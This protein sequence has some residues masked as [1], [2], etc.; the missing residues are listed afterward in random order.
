M[1]SLSK[2]FILFTFVCNF[3]AYIIFILLSRQ[4]S[5]N[6]LKYYHF[7]FQ[8]HYPGEVMR[9]IY[10]AL[11]L[12]CLETQ[13]LCDFEDQKHWQYLYRQTKQYTSLVIRVCVTKILNHMEILQN[14]FVQ[15][16]CDVN[17]NQPLRCIPLITFKGKE[18]YTDISETHGK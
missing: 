11:D 15:C 18:I 9:F 7:R 8:L 14:L 12:L 17:P 6:I 4:C 2:E 5:F 16:W 10:Q 1:V 13:H 3:V